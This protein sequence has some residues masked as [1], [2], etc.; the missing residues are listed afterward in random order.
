MVVKEN[1]DRKKKKRCGCSRPEV[2]FKKVFLEI[3][4]NS[5]ENTSVRV[6]FLLKFQK[7]YKNTFS[8]RTPL[9][10]A[11]DNEVMLLSAILRQNL[12]WFLS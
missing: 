6:S 5:Q 3:S 4:Q 7:A 12:S 11:S 1:P 10:A 2:F 9:V 8:Y